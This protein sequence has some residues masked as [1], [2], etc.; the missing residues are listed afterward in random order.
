MDWYRDLTE[1]VTKRQ[2]HMLEMLGELV[3]LESPTED[4]EA[5]NRCVTL[6]EGWI[7]ASGGKTGAANKGGRGPVDR[8]FGPGAQRRPG[9]DAA[10][11]LDTVW[12]LCTLRNAF[13]GGRGTGWGPGVLDMKAG[14]VMALSALCI[15]QEA[16]Q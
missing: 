8:P 9:P 7:K 11:H 2:P 12:P 4:P 16:G 15:L 5:V 1:A 14:V 6:V 3:R 10:R 13:P